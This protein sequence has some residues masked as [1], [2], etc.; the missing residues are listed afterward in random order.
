MAEQAVCLQPSSYAGAVV[1]R[2]RK[3]DRRSAWSSFGQVAVANLGDHRRSVSVPFPH[4]CAHD[5]WWRVLE[6]AFAEI[7]PRRS[8]VRA[9]LAPLPL[10]VRPLPGHDDFERFAC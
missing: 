7:A 9:R 10:E 8:P 2:A 6:K 3:G 4:E 1:T 5:D